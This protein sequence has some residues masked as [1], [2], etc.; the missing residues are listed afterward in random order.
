MVMNNNVNLIVVIDKQYNNQDQEKHKYNLI[1]SRNKIFVLSYINLNIV[2][3]SIK[4]NIQFL[5]NLNNITIISLSKN[6][7]IVI[8]NNK[9]NIKNNYNIQF[10]PKII[11]NNKIITEIIYVNE[12]P[13][14]IKRHLN[15][16]V[17][18]DN[19]IRF[20]IHNTIYRFISKIKIN[21]GVFIGGEMYIYGKILDNFVK[22]KIYYSDYESLIFDAKLNDSQLN[23]YYLIDYQNPN[24]LNKIKDSNSII[25][26]NVSKSGLGIN[27]CNQLN[28]IKTKYLILIECSKKSMIKDLQYLYNYNVLHKFRYYTNY[29][30]FIIIL[31]FQ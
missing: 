17:Q 12:I 23:K 26:C 4:Q 16:F 13:Y 5:L 9:I 18:P 11:T 3:E 31:F 8:Y 28:N 21:L 29:E 20:L 14:K 25:I 27:L 2:D 24:C 7:L 30:I 19:T 22:N 15:S 10:I 1:P 6:K